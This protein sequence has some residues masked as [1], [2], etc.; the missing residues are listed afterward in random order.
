TW[1][2]MPL[3]QKELKMIQELTAFGIRKKCPLPDSHV[4]IY[5]TKFGRSGRLWEI[6]PSPHSF[7]SFH[8]ARPVINKSELTPC[9]LVENCCEGIYNLLRTIMTQSFKRQRRFIS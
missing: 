5:Y 1:D 7:C 2:V 4:V 6:P 9:D 8:C 3:F